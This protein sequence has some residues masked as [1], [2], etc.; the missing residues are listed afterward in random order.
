MEEVAFEQSFR[1]QACHGDKSGEG[2][3][4]GGN[5]LSKVNKART[6]TSPVHRYIK[7]SVS[8]GIQCRV[9]TSQEVFLPPQQL[10]KPRSWA[11]LPG[12]WF[13]GCLPELALL[14]KTRPVGMGIGR[15]RTPSSA[16]SP[17]A[18]TTSRLYTSPCLFL[19]APQHPHSVDA[20]GC[21]PQELEP[22]GR[23]VRARAPPP[24]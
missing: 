7:H 13:S 17:A 6:H 23:E 10:E 2:F 4:S 18:T 24:T 19:V 1:E 3:P 12:S 20:E 5:S 22:M 11:I 8:L 16:A 14:G 15:S 21:G 9:F